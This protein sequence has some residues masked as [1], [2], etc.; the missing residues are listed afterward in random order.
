V[1]LK[2]KAKSKTKKTMS[3][4]SLVGQAKLQ[5]DLHVD[6]HKIRYNDSPTIVPNQIV[7]MRF[8][9][10]DDRMLDLRNIFMCF[11]LQGSSTDANALMDGSTIQTVID[12]IRV[13]SGSVVLCDIGECSLLFQSLYDLNTEVNISSAEKYKLGDL[14]STVGKAAFAL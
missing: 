2:R 8:P 12:R 6:K 5:G 9:K 4:E 3:V 13:L 1:C 10:Y 14:S 11:F 7:R